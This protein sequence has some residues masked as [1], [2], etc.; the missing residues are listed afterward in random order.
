[1]LKF[2]Y[3]QRPYNQS[4]DYEFLRTL[5][6]TTRPDLR[7]AGLPTDTL[8]TVLDQQFEVQY[9]HYE[10]RFGHAEHTIVTLRKKPI[11]RLWLHTASDDIRIVQ[12][13]M[14][15]KYRNG[16]IGTHLIQQQSKRAMET[17]RTLTLHVE[18]YNADAK[19]LYTRLNF[20]DKFSDHESHDFMQW[21]PL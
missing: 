18:Q 4:R 17:D 6:H 7:S 13:T 9:K 11:G 12:V 15:P 20:K 16:G 1:M 5:Y 8:T 10:Q 2:K 3:N 14:L 21:Q 19:R